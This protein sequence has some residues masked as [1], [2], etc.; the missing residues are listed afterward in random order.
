[1]RLTFEAH[2]MFLLDS[3]GTEHVSDVGINQPTLVYYWLRAAPEKLTLLCFEFAART[4]GKHS[5]ESHKDF[6]WK[7][8]GAVK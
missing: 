3:I 8:V 7:A 6:P 5:A 1:M 4:R 2:I